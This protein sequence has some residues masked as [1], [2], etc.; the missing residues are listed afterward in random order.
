MPVSS[1]LARNVPSIRP[2]VGSSGRPRNRALHVVEEDVHA[3]DGVRAANSGD[4][5]RLFD[6]GNTSPA[7]S[8]TMAFRVAV[9][10]QPGE[11]AAAGPCGI[12]RSCR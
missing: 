1:R 8:M 4:H 11:R 10:H 5:W 2:T 9:R 6:D 7:I 12:G 3:A